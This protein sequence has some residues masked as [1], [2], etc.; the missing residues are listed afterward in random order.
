MNALLDAAV[1]YGARGW[2]VFPC[3]PA[4]KRPLTPRGERGEG[5][6]KHATTDAATIRAWWQRFPIALIGMRTGAASGLFVVDVDAGVDEET[7]EVFE[8]DKLIDDLE[9][10]IGVK[11]TQTWAVATPRGG[12]HLYYQVPND[13]IVGN[14]TDLLG[15]RSRIDIR[16]ENGYVILPPSVRAD[17]HGYTWLV[18][19][20]IK[21][22]RP[23]RAP[24]AL[25]DCSLRLG[26]W[27][28]G[29]DRGD[30]PISKRAPAPR[31]AASTE[32]RGEAI[33]RYG[34]AALVNQTKAVGQASAGT[35]N[36]ALNKAALALGHLVGA[37]A[38]S[39]TVVRTALEEACRANGLAKDDGI[40]SVRGTIESGLKAGIAQ[41]TDLS[42]I[43]T[44]AGK[45]RP[46]EPLS[47]DTPAGRRRAPPQR[48]VLVGLTEF[49][50]LWHDADRDPYVSFTV[51]T[52]R[53]HW[54]I[55]SAPFRRLLAGRFF[56][57]TGATIGGQALEDTL[58]LL[59]A[60]AAKGP[61]Y[62]PYRRIGTANAKI[63][64]DLC[65]AKWRA[66]EIDK[67]GW[68]I[69]AKPPVKFLRARGMRPLPDPEAG[70]EIALLRSFLN[71]RSDDDFLIIVAWCIGALRP[72][73]PYAVLAV[74]GEQGSAKSFFFRVLRSLVD[75]SIAPIRAAPR[76]ERD[77]LVQAYNAHII[78]LDNLSSIAPWLADALCR[79]STGGGLSTRMLH[80]DRDEVIFE[81]ARP[82]M[83]NGIP[84]LTDRADL[85]SRSLEINLPRI[86]E[87]KHRLEDELLAEFEIAR[88]RIL[89][90]F[91]DAVSSALKNLASTK[92]AAAP[93]L[94]DF[95]KWIVAASP[96]LGWEPDQFLAA[97]DQNRRDVGES[98]FEADHVAM[99][100]RDL[101]AV[102][103]PNGWQGTATELL[104]ALDLRASEG[105]RKSQ[106][107][108][109]SAH[110]LGNR[111][112]RA[113]PLLRTRGITV[114]RRRSGVR[115]I[116]IGPVNVSI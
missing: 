30:E 17:G 81:A 57:E 28:R 96:G 9:R 44:G 22:E 68:Q 98:A 104:A 25:L 47:G 78:A 52:H 45:G 83:L 75:P 71:V 33:R 88:P 32:A 86:P 61:E 15:S 105:L 77:L 87:G 102:D 37:N 92:L 27:E 101:V 90:A 89:G 14:R 48:D 100:I 54:P 95:A 84:Q 12:Q 94:A 74:S 34:A 43:G 36:D 85:A 62:V 115:T 59:E 10:V 73:G 110:A 82:V 11:L 23:A 66:V 103:H 24:Q 50:E 51:D 109:K 8:V 55:R 93:R 49:D 79:L 67:D 56:E 40:A 46:H 107:W 53:E 29:A 19:P 6:V 41:P 26:K 99:A 20:K 65:D 108:P 31:A 76:D 35:R 21:D 7:G 2:P 39:E 69:I 106:A 97:Y 70:Y 1:G 116:A 18:E 42:K 3:H 16:G 80:T 72:N 91:L 111:I 63:Y 13:T 64:L 112:E 58:R 38:L 5:G 114:E 60:R 113:A 4:T